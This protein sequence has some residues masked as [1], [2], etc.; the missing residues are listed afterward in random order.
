MWPL[1]MVSWGRV[2]GSV[3]FEKVHE[4]FLLKIYDEGSPQED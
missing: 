4:E 1:A 3:Q 2:G